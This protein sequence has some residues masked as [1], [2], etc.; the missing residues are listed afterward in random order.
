MKGI[1][2]SSPRTLADAIRPID[3]LCDRFDWAVSLQSGPF[4]EIHFTEEDDPRN[5]LGLF[6]DFSDREPFWF[7]RGLLPRHAANLIFDEWSYYLGFDVNHVDPRAFY[8]LL[9][10]DIS[11]RPHLFD[12]VAVTP[13]VYLIFVDDGWWEGYS[14]IDGVENHLKQAWKGRT[15]DSNRWDG[16]HDN[17]HP[18]PEA[19]K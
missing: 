18:F 5:V 9:N 13:C 6:H 2:A 10:G 1:F 8:T 4:R 19:A 7:R 16:R 12:A 11:P 15:V 3:A 14:M 17:L